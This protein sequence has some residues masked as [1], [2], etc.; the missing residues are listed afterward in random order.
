[1]AA[2]DRGDGQSH[3][4]RQEPAQ[5]LPRRDLVSQRK[6]LAAKLV[7]GPG[8]T[9]GGPLPNRGDHGGQYNRTGKVFDRDVRGPAGKLAFVG[10]KIGAGLAFELTS[11]LAKYEYACG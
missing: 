11:Y 5:R 10:E 1:M 7:V 6:T 9:G 3:D 8:G 2:N 4:L